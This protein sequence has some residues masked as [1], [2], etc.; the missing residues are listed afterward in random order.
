MKMAGQHIKGNQMGLIKKYPLES[1]FVI[2]FSIMYL[3]GIIG[4]Y[5]LLVVPEAALWI[6]G[7]FAPTIA[8]VIVL[9]IS[10]GK[11]GIK[12]L[13]GTFLIWKVGFK[14]Y[15]A[16]VSMTI[17]AAAVAVGYL[18]YQGLPIPEIPIGFA[19]AALFTTLFLGPLSEEAGWSGYAL[20][21]LQSRYDALTSSLILGALWAV[22]H[23]PL[24]F[25]PGSP[26]SDMPFVL[27]V[28]VLMALRLIMSW[29]FNNTNGSLL[30]AVLFHLFFNYG[31][32][33]GIQ[34]MGVPA[35]HMLY[36]FATALVVYAVWIVIVAGPANFS[37]KNTRIK[38]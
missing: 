28:V 29:A 17:I 7:S 37:R 36:L 4:V 8:A 33:L 34:V 26:Q 35:S 12:K 13:F 22:W 21:R 5:K 10:E 3:A 27:F 30:I 11:T 25:F 32:G 38:I 15:F 19:L 18:Y 20:P 2:V 14:W 6:V 9:G 31:S 23:A 1:F 24:W 16:A